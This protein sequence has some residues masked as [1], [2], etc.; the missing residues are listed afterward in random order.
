MRISQLSRQTG[1]SVATIKF[2]L[3]EGLL[4]PGERTARNQARYDVEHVERLRLIQTLTTVGGMGISATR[5]VLEA[6]D[7]A[8]MSPCDLR[9]VVF[10]MLYA[11]RSSLVDGDQLAA[12][13]A[14]VDSYLA[15]LGWTVE[16]D[17]TARDTVATVFAEL[18]RLGWDCDVN[19]FAPLAEVAARLATG[20]H[21]LV[22]TPGSADLARSAVIGT[23]L[24]E[25]ALIALRRLAEDHYASLGTVDHPGL[26]VPPD[27]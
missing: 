15:S 2:Y 16:C 12:A 27:V 24:L 1:V 20:G 8:Q 18:R 13:R 26:R 17:S 4:P 11:Q 3:R 10:R 5:T 22:S 25:N 14:A 9:L 7:S 19:V 21:R 23:V 6:V